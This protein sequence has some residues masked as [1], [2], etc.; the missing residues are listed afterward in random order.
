MLMIFILFQILHFNETTSTTQAVTF[1]ADFFGNRAGGGWDP[2][3]ANEPAMFVNGILCPLTVQQTTRN[4]DLGSVLGQAVSHGCVR[5]A[6]A[7]VV[8]V[9]ERVKVG[10]AVVV[11]P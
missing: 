9:F 7:D 8:K 4:E 3:R 5:M 2:T 11:E 1:W 6:N 10:T